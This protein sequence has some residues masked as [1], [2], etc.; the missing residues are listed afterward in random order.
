LLW[1]ISLE[2]IKCLEGKDPTT[3][4]IIPH[5]PI[6]FVEHDPFGGDILRNLT[7]IGGPNVECNLHRKVFAESD[8]VMVVISSIW[9]FPMRMIS[10]TGDFEPKFDNLITKLA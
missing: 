4:H 3:L 6:V 9:W 2:I 10:S 8:F 1:L 7:S 5:S